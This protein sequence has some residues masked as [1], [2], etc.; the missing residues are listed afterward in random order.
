MHDDLPYDVPVLAVDGQGEPRGYLAAPWGAI[1]SFAYE[2]AAD[3]WP[4]VL[5]LL[6]HHAGRLAALPQPPSHVR[7]P[8]PADATACYAIADH[9]PVHSEALSRPHAGWMA[10]LVDVPAV[11]RAL[12]PAWQ[13]RWQRRGARSSATFALEVE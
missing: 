2:A 7:W 8:L 5:A 4:A 9:L 13:E 10:S 3:D 12:L 1:R 11:L 6:Q